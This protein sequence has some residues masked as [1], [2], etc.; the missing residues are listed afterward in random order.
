MNVKATIKKIIPSYI[1]YK[2]HERKYK[3]ELQERFSSNHVPNSD[4]TRLKIIRSKDDYSSLKKLMKTVQINSNTYYFYSL[5]YFT[6]IFSQ[7]AITDNLT[8]DYSLAMLPLSEIEKNNQ[9]L[10]NS[11]SIFEAI[12]VYISRATEYLRQHPSSRNDLLCS[13]LENILDS[14]PKSFDEALQ[15]ILFYNQLLWQTGHRLMGLGRL[16]LILYPY[17]ENDIKSGLIDSKKAAFMVS[18]FMKTLHKDYVFKSNALLGD[19]GQLIILG[20]Y[21]KKGRTVSNAL[22]KIFITVAGELQ[23]PDPKILLRVT[24]DTNREIFSLSLKSIQSGLGF[25]LFAND[26]VIIPSLISSGFDKEDVWNYATSACWEPIIP[27]KSTDHNNYSNIIL[28][29]PLHRILDEEDLSKIDDFSS[30]LSIYKKCLKNYVTDMMEESMGL[31]LA[32]DPLLSIFTSGG[33]KHKDIAEGGAKYNNIGYLSLSFG[34][35]INSLLIIKKYVFEDKKYTLAE[36]DELRKKEKMP[37]L[38]VFPEFGCDDAEIINLTN[39]IMAVISETLKGRKNSLGGFYKVGYSSPS[40]ISASSQTSASFDGRKNGDPF[41]VHISTNA[42]L[43]YTELM[44]FAGKLKYSNSVCNGNVL[45]FI[46]SRD[47]ID[48]NFDNFVDFLMFSTESGYF[49]TQMNVTSSKLLIEA[50]KNPKK[51]PNL[52]VRVWGFSAYFNDLPEEYKNVLI[53]RALKSEGKK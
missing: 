43:S 42:A 16:D 48:N 7:G 11:D 6:H 29:E 17:Y 5:D 4:A 1:F 34:N 3:N 23:L 31:R 8:I 25:P 45:D 37:T 2:H 15:R 51:F 28:L 26:E 19:T 24:K 46:V 53:E 14:S 44:S 18:E 30:L 36:L 38:P 50:K 35:L 47:F 12:R 40:Y 21:D 41:M 9:K 13:Y 32:F 22:T 10:R 49:E 52:I 39:S 33:K 20:G 27:S